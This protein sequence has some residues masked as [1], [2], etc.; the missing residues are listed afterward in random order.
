MENCNAVNL[1]PP[2]PSGDA[3]K[4]TS[5]NAKTKVKKV[6]SKIYGYISSQSI[7][8]LTTGTRVPYVI[9]Q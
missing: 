6:Q 1:Q 7:T 2:L 3:N 9:I 4:A 8:C 5:V